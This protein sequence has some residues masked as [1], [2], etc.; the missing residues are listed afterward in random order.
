MKINVTWNTDENARQAGKVCA[1][2]AVLDLI[3][4]KLAIIFSSEKYNQ[5]EL[6]TGAKSVLGTAPII[7]C[8]S[9]EGIIVSDGYINPEKN[10]FAGMMAIGDYETKVGTAISRNLESA[11]ETG[12]F[13]AKEAMQKVGTKASPSY[14]FMFATAGNEEEYA[15]G[16]KDIIGDVPCFGG[17]PVENNKKIFTEDMI[18]T[19][20]VAVAFFY[21]NKKIENVFASKYHE[22]VNSGVITKVNGKKILEEIDE[23]KALKKYCEWTEKKVRELKDD[24]I[25]VESILKPL[26]VKT[27]DGTLAVIKHPIKGN[28]DYSITFENEIFSNTAI[29]QM[30]ISENELLTS[31]IYTIR[32]LK[33]KLKNKPAG[34]LLLQNYQRKKLIEE[35][36]DEFAKKLKCEIGDVPFIM[37]FT[38][39]EYG[40]GEYISN[41]FSRL[42]LSDIA[43]C[44]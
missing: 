14:Y 16:I 20:G 39:S 9:S 24:K 33:K 43:I 4:T 17:S 30:Q 36:I 37:T 1:K 12:R 19:D 5:E 2:K 38:N 6:L 22:T 26:A 23:I 13:V 21:S 35:N 29:V 8:T 31:P 27:S 44:E 11:R 40:K 7:G 34:F 3:Q 41:H 32:E 10:G 15:K 25:Y 42:M 28:N 18:I